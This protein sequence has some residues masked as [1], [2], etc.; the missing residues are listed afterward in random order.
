MQSI[1]SGRIL[2]TF[3]TYL[4]L[5]IPRPATA[6]PVITVNDISVQEGNTGTT[7]ATFTFVRSYTGQTS[8][9][10]Y[11]TQPLRTSLM[12]TV[13]GSGACGGGSDYIGA[14]GT[15]SFTSSERSKTVNVQICP[16]YTVE[17][18]NEMFLLT[19]SSHTGAKRGTLYAKCTIVDDDRLPYVTIEDYGRLE[20]SSS[21]SAFW[22]PITLEK[23]STQ[24]VTVWFD[25]RS[26]TDLPHGT[27]DTATAGTSCGGSTDYWG[28]TGRSIVFS[29]GETR[30]SI[31][32]NVCGDT[33][34]EPEETFS[35][36]L[37]RAEGAIPRGTGRGTIYND[38]LP[39]L[40]V[41]D[42][43]VNEGGTAYC[44][45]RLSST[46]HH[47]CYV[48]YR[49]I[50]GTAYPSDMY[51]ACSNA[52]DVWNKSGTASFSDGTD[53]IMIEIPT[54]GDTVR[55]GNET[56]QIHFTNPRGLSVPD[57]LAVGTIIDND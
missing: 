35:V 45:L 4:L 22:F 1:P 3:G 42:F 8:S 16:D 36:V 31:D 23:S 50:Q 48:D 28:A 6:Q 32:V 52:S 15:V 37:T 20:G 26:V 40:S 13:E 47:G 54:C 5:C 29:P 39:V 57:T 10:A 17:S 49:V 11:A 33:T 24:R 9:V 44:Q 18:H 53:Y 7:T 19:L 41:L 21:S 55:E 27:P 34:I 51:Q 25:V 14:R 2:V 43:N 30:K 38:D 12:D 46:N 56:F